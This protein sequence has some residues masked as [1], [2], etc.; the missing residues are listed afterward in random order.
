LLRIINTP[1]R[2]IGDT[3]VLKVAA[4]ANELGISVSQALL[5]AAGPEG[6]LGAATAKKLAAF[7]EL[8]DGLR[9]AAV[10]LS[11]AALAEKVLE[12]TGYQASLAAEASLE[13]EGRLENLMELVA[14]MREYETE[15]SNLGE[16][17]SLA[18]FLERVALVADIDSYD[19]DK[20]AVSMM[21][22]HT[23]KGLEFPWVFVTGMEE[24][25]FPHQRSLEDDT[26]L[27]EERRLCYV[28]VTRAMKRLYMTRARVRRLGGQMF[29]GAPSRFL[30]DV[31]EDCAEHLVMARPSYYNVDTDE[32]GPWQGGWNRGGAPKRPA[33]GGYSGG[34]A[35]RR[36]EPTSSIPPAP[37]KAAAPRSFVPDEDPGANHPGLRVGG[38]LRHPKFGVGEV[39]GWTGTGED[40]KVTMKFSSV[41]IKTIL[42]KFLSAP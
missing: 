32:A 6:G 33:S 19:P 26:Q 17:P 22:V 10:D 37:P 4:I 2:G 39:K 9:K 20:G 14:L 31:P 18:G 23:A 7:V 8:M 15:A 30:R 34:F 27:E 41:G 25:V 40:L 11:P 13:A 42:A 24:G 29:G 1:A 36:S 38:K 35:G 3:T 28:A 21:T 16:A 12:D 5:H